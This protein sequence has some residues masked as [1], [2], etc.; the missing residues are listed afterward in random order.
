MIIGLPT[1]GGTPLALPA[2]QKRVALFDVSVEEVASKIELY[3]DTIGAPGP[4]RVR[5]VVYDHAGVL[6]GVGNEVVVPPGLAPGWLTLPLTEST[7]E[8]VYLEPGQVYLGVHAGDAGLNVYEVAAAAASVIFNTD[9]YSDGASNPFGSSTPSA[10]SM[11]LYAPTYPGW[12]PATKGLEVVLGRLPFSESQ[13]AFRTT[14]PTNA[15]PKQARVAWHGTGLN[16]ERGAFATAQLNGI[17]DPFV[18]ER[19]LISYGTAPRREVAVYVNDLA[20]ID[21]DLSLA[22]RAFK[23]LAPLGDD[24]ITAI[25]TVLA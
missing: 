4:T 7:P 16:A 18:G 22:R 15:P 1:P 12:A 25:V 23:A 19:L 5:A 9:T 6:L 20:E 24:E 3:G 8:G 10:T 2:N 14:G 21:Q 13:V 11:V 17:F